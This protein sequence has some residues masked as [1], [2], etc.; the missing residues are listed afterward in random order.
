[1]SMLSEGW[2]PDNF[3]SFNSLKPGFTNICGLC[4]NFIECESFLESNSSDILALCETNL[5]Y[6]IDFN[7][8][9]VVGYLPLIQKDS[10][11]RAFILHETYL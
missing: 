9:S 6:S 5:E 1:M 10:S 2:K 3:E 7:N 4:S 11:I 8:F